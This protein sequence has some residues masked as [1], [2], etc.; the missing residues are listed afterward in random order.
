MQHRGRIRLA[1][2]IAGC[3]LA[4]AIGSSAFAQQQNLGEVDL[5]KL[6]IRDSI[7]AY[8]KSC[9]CPYSANRAGRA[10]G[11]HSAYSR[12]M[13]GPL[14]CYPGDIPDEQL[15]RYRERYQQ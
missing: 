8:G 3:A 2:G 1:L 14:M 13:G 15:A 10:C 7:A 11:E 9:P 5:W 4:L 12:K 6:I